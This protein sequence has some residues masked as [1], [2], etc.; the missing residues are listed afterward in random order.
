MVAI[1]GDTWL[2]KVFE[3]SRTCSPEL[4]RMP[5]AMNR[6]NASD[7]GWWPRAQGSDCEVREEKWSRARWR[8]T[9]QDWA[10]GVMREET[11][12]LW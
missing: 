5:D 8:L 2:L 6:G 11:E 4:C 1:V 10:N 9:K 3:E 7:R 12:H